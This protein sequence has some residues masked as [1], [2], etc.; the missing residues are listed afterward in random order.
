MTEEIKPL[1]QPKERSALFSANIEGTRYNKTQEGKNT[2]LW[3]RPDGNRDIY[4]FWEE[5]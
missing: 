5:L 1:F 2:Y 3:D 4:Q